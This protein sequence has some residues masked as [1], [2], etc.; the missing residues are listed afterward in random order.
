MGS[1]NSVGI[2]VAIRDW[3]ASRSMVSVIL[4]AGIGGMTLNFGKVTITSVACALIMGILTNLLCSA[5]K[6]NKTEQSA[7]DADASV[8]AKSIEDTESAETK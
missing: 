1:M 5:G 7:A 4:I 8:A 6:K 3:C 2:L